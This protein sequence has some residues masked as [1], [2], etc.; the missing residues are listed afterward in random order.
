Q[1]ALR[2]IEKNCRML[3]DTVRVW[4]LRAIEST[5]PEKLKWIKAK[6]RLNP[7]AISLNPERWEEDGLFNAEPKNTELMERDIQVY[8]GE[9]KLSK[10]QSLYH[11][12]R[13]YLWGWTMKTLEST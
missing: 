11:L 7:Y 6:G 2:D 12:F 13:L 8:C 1:Q 9:L 3:E 10:I 4:F 5:M